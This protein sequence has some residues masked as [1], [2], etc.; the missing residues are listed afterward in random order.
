MQTQGL[1]FCRF[2]VIPSVCI[3]FYCFSTL[4]AFCKQ[5]C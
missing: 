1:A 2:S 5:S 4:S 3:V